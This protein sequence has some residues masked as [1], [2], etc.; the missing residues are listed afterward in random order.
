[1]TKKKEKKA[2][3][4]MRKS[5]LRITQDILDYIEYARLKGCSLTGPEDPEIRNIN[6]LN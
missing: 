1:M 2:G 3:K 6:V 5:E 4:Y